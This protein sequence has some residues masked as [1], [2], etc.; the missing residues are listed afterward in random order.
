MGI[1]AK[2]YRE[3]VLSIEYAW[4]PDNMGGSFPL[5]SSLSCIRR[6]SLRQGRLK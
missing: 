2:L 5:L 1:Y 4:L 6:L 3:D